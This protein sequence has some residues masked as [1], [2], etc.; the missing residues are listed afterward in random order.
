MRRSDRLVPLR[1]VSDVTLRDGSDRVEVTTTIDNTAADHRI[2][3]LFPTGLAGD[4][5]ESDSAFDVVRRPVALPAVNDGRRELDLETRPH[6]SWTA[7]GDGK[8]GLAVVARGLPEVA[9]RDTPD[10]PIALTLLRGFRRV[11]SRDDDAGGQVL[12][13]H[14]FRYDLVPFAGPTPTRRLF[15]LG[16]RLHA[17][18]RQASVA[19]PLRPPT[20]VEPARLPR[21]GSFAEIHGEVI[22]TSVRRAAGQR[23]IRVF[24]PSVDAAQVVV[25]GGAVRSVTLDGRPDDRV[26]VGPSGITVPGKRIAT[27]ERVVSVFGQSP[28][29]PH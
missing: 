20:T 4:S 9:V 22:V 15:L 12:G 23:T 28:A 11:I 18:V 10:R 26:R 25:G 6:L 17:T 24:S 5:F 27:L 3:V 8:V 29:A 2:R 16:Q 13:P 1:I 21:T 19:T 14:T 7:F